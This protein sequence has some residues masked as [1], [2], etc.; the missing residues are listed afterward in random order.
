[1][2]ETIPGSD[3]TIVKHQAPAN[4]RIGVAEDEQVVLNNTKGPSITD[5]VGRGSQAAILEAFQRP[6]FTTSSDIHVP[7]KRKLSS[8]KP[9]KSKQSKILS[10]L[11]FD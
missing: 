9:K 6:V 4:K 2:N 10:K 5:Q 1:M 3:Y 11:Q 7:K 8:P